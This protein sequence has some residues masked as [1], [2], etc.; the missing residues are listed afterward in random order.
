MAVDEAFTNV[1]RHTYRMEFGQKVRVRLSFLENDHLHIELE[2]DGP[3][4]DPARIKSRALEEIKP[5]GLGVHFI[6]TIMDRVEYLP[7]DS[8]NSL[9]M[10]KYL[11]SQPC[12]KEENEEKRKADLLQALLD[13]GQSLPWILDISTLLALIVKK[14]KELMNC[15]GASVLLLDRENHELV[16]HT[17]LDE[18]G[19]AH[20]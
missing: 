15:Q 17:V 14:V 1:I 13:I 18:I 4:M 16:F 9:R 8:G 2:D 6:H 20:V 19:R 12:P 3:P 10:W 7:G 11:K 5:G